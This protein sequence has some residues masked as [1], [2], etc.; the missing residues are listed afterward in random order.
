MYTV[1]QKRRNLVI[2]DETSTPMTLLIPSTQ[3]HVFRVTP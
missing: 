3:L 1:T 2:I